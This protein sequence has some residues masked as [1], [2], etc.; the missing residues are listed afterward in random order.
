M[1]GHKYEEIYAFS[2]I[3]CLNW[4]EMFLEYLNLS[5]KLWRLKKTFVSFIWSSFLLFSW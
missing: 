1:W 2:S 4:T 5:L 3:C